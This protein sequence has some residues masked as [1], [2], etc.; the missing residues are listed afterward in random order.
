[1]PKQETKIHFLSEVAWNVRYREKFY[2]FLDKLVGGWRGRHYSVS[3]LE[4]VCA[5]CGPQF[6][7]QIEVPGQQHTTHVVLPGA[8]HLTHYSALP[9]WQLFRHRSVTGGLQRLPPPSKEKRVGQVLAAVADPEDRDM[10]L[11]NIG[12]SPNYTKLQPGAMYP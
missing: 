7:N 6:G 8:V 9:V 2:F 11:R 3:I 12:L 5:A 1:M 4:Y 10:F